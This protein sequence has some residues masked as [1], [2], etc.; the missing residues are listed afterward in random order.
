MLAVR[1]EYGVRD[2]LDR[3]TMLEWL[4]E[5]R[6]PERAIGRFW[7]PVLVSAINVELDRMAAT[8]GQQV[9][10][11]GFLATAKSYEMGVPNVPLGQLCASKAWQDY[12]AVSIEFRSPVREFVRDDNMVR[13]AM[14]DDGAATADYFV[15]AV[16][17]ERAAALTPGIDVEFSGWGNSS[18]TTVHLWFDRTVTGLPHGALLD[19][20]IHWFFNKD[21]GRYLQVVVSASDSLLSATK[22]DVV[23]MTVR[24]LGEFLPAVREAT[25]ERSRVVKEPRATIVAAPGLDSQ[26]PGPR[27]R[28]RNLFV[29]G[30]WTRTGWPSTMEGAVRSGYLAAEAVTEAAGS[31][32][33]FVV[34]DLA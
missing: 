17:F 6:Q 23:A 24:E 30:D 29:A 19:R 26:R 2:D 15:S 1:S 34:P 22:R 3:I 27:T 16:P 5:K 33:R 32:R 18:I 8:Y 21:R 9:I 25:L 14:T 31:P 28:L 10:R 13:E 20:T 7:R 12:P 4:R 11:L